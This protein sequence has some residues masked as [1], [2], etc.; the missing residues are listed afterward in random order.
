MEERMSEFHKL[1]YGLLDT[2]KLSTILRFDVSKIIIDSNED[3]VDISLG[4]CDEDNCIQTIYGMRRRN[5]TDEQWNRLLISLNRNTFKAI[6]LESINRFIVTEALAESLEYCFGIPR[7]KTKQINKQKENIKVSF[8]LNLVQDKNGMAIQLCKIT[9]PYILYIVL[10]PCISALIDTYYDALVNFISAAI[11][12]QKGSFYHQIG[13]CSPWLE[14][15]FDAAFRDVFGDDAGKCCRLSDVYRCDDFPTLA[16]VLKTIGENQLSEPE[17]DE[18]F[19]DDS[20]LL[21]DSQ[22]EEVCYGVKNRLYAWRNRVGFLAPVPHEIA[23]TRMVYIDS[24]YGYSFGINL[25]QTGKALYNPADERITPHEETIKRFKWD[26]L[27][28]PFY[29]VPR[30]HVN[31]S[32]E[33]FELLCTM[34]C[35]GLVFRGQTSEYHLNRSPELMEKLYGDE[36]AKEPSLASLALRSGDYFENHFTEWALLIKEYVSLCIGPDEASALL[37]QMNVGN[38]YMFCLAV[39]QHY[40]LPT[41]GLDVSYSIATA[42]FFSLFEYHPKTSLD[43]QSQYTRKVSGESIIYLF[44]PKEP[45]MFDFSRF[46]ILN[47]KYK[48]FFRPIAQAASFAHAS[49]GMAKNSIAERLQLAIHFDVQDID[50]ETI[51]H[52]LKAQHYPSLAVH[53]FF[54]KDDPFILFLRNKYISKDHPMAAYPHVSKFMEYL[55]KY[56]YQVE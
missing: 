51:N 24:F 6:L 45:E 32:E 34:Q 13:C 39:A 19:L 54:P 46:D 37:G 18:Q 8:L 3:I 48:L 27:R 7:E 35:Y 36:N 55:K 21:M 47:R 10:D 14:E 15:I 42:L 33:L 29:A 11:T 38:F 56:I 5:L 41:F 9:M 52:L 30:V 4:T 40:G 2:N 16:V 43:G 28:V 49:W 50:L 53:S 23:A 12:S 20:I 25:F 31:N 22:D 1:L 44:K 26:C 17:T